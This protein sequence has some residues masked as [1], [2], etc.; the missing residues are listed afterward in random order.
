MN[1][2]SHHSPDILTCIS[3]LSSDEVFTPPRIVHMMLDTLPKDIWENLEIKFLDPVSKSG[4]FLREI[5]KRL[6]IGLEK[7]IPDK[8][9]RIQHILKNQVFGIGITRLTT[10]ISKRSVY[11]SRK[12]NGKLSI[13][14]FI[15][16]FGNIRYFEIP[17][18]WVKNKYCGYCGVSKNIYDRDNQFE[19]YSYSFIHVKDPKELFN[20]KFDVIVGNP[21]YQM[22]DGSGKGAGATPIYDKFVNQAIRLNPRY[23][24]MIIPSRWFSGGRG[25]D[26]FREK[27]LKD[28]RFVEIHDFM[29]AA[30]CFPGVEIKGGVNYF[31]WSSSYRG[32]CKIITYENGIKESE[33]LR[34]LDEFNFLVRYNQA[35]SMIKKVQSKNLHSF[36][37]I[38]MSAKPFGFRTFFTGEKQQTPN[39][40]KIFVNGGVAY[41][42]RNKV[43]IN[44]DLIDKHKVLVPY[45]FG[46]GD[47]KTD[48]IKPIYSPPGTCCS[49]T[50][51]VIGPFD[52]KK[53]CE[54]VMNFLNTKFFHFFITLKKNTQHATKNAYELVPQMNFSKN[55][56]D[57]KIFSYFNFENSEIDFIRKIIW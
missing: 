38:V 22:S 56:T 17:H 33:S 57:D 42:K 30:D 36:M 23:I 5:T 47:P 6:L 54:N 31:L 45:A 10:E 34:D 28:K 37:N 1:E 15:D 48:K 11:L 25:L 13:V 55:W 43:V 52:N 51:L 18:F 16:E 40:I 3:N 24:T 2:Q 29:N 8:K 32:K 21:P 44:A 53:E 7:K 27:M 20:M 35:I 26:K 46:S 4:V 9:K 39:S 49:E 12:A 19:S 14:N 50:Y 41:V